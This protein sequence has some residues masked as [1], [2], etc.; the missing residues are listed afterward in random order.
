MQRYFFHVHEDDQ[1]ILIDTLGME[2]EGLSAMREEAIE[3][4]RFAYGV[5]LISAEKQ[6]ANYRIEITDACG[7]TSLTMRIWPSMQLA[8]LKIA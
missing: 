6:N 1:R 3:C 7:K 5:G 2:L 4:A 8:L